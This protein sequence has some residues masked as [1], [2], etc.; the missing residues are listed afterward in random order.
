MATVESVAIPSL[1]LEMLRVD[2]NAGAIIVRS[3]R[4]GVRTVG[5][6]DLEIPTDWRGR[7]WLRFA[8]YDRSRYVSAIE[9]LNGR[10]PPGLLK[11]KLVLIGTS[12]VGL[13]DIKATPIDPTMPGVEVHAQTIDN[14]LNGTVLKRPA[15]ATAL[16]YLVALL[17]SLP[18]IAFG[19]LVPAGA[20]FLGGGAVAAATMSFAWVSFASFGYLVDFTFPLA[21]SLSVYAIL[22]ATN[23]LRASSDRHW[24]RSAFSQYISPALVE[25]LANSPEKLVL[26]G[27]RRE[28]T[29]MFSDVRGF[30][31]LSEKYKDDPQGLTTLLNRLLTPLT[32]CIIEHRGT[33]DKYVGDGIM[34][35]WNAPV[36]D[37]KHE[38][39]A[40]AAALS[41]LDRLKRLNAARAEEGQVSGRPPQPL[42]M[43]I[44]INTG[45][46][47]V[48]NFGSDLHFNYSVLGDTVNLASRLE[49][50][51]K[52]Y[53]VPI[54]LG[55][56]T[57]RAVAGAF[58]VLEL[59][60]VQVVGKSEPERVFTLLGS[61]EVRT[62]SQFRR[63]SAHHRSVLSAYRDRDWR[64][65]LE[66]IVPCRELG[67]PYGL[68]HYYGTMVS[69]IRELIE[70]P[71]PTEWA[72]V[73]VL[74][75][76]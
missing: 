14:A 59:D 43:G 56:R 36:S 3:D 75:Q 72:G 26:G 57:A 71:P 27:D 49:S 5:L 8:P 2:R 42:R 50:Q 45:P 17:I 15:A 67:A 20:L 38:V 1:P 32:K 7:A 35:F 33:I 63:L 61:A 74:S 6:H 37:D 22:V 48:G 4:N 28:M 30:T 19:P 47:F 25:Q 60:L 16:E 10:T 64:R 23:Y 46:C 24:I 54:V 65:A 66:A 29:V 62:S 9:V 40:C 58:A 31:A 39:N 21:T 69:R 12:A 68:E 18:L 44:G 51:S 73:T 52:Q 70:A 34:A 53:G 76:K 55:E 41:M 13:L 11:D